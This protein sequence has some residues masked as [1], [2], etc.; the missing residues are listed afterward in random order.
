MNIFKSWTSPNK[1]LS[2]S[3]HSSN[4]QPALTLSIIS[5]G[6]NSDPLGHHNNNHFGDNNMAAATDYVNLK[7]PDAAYINLQV[8]IIG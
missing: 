4:H 3:N 5:T 6:I 7:S 1:W 8:H 2:I